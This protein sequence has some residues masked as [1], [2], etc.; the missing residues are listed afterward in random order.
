MHEDLSADVTD[1]LQPE[2]FFTPAHVTICKALYA[3]ANR[4]EANLLAVKKELEAC[5]QLQQI[6][7]GATKEDGV[8][9]LAELVEN[10]GFDTANFGYYAKCVQDAA[11]LRQLLSI[12]QRMY[13]DAK[14]SPVHEATRVIEE[15]QGQLYRLGIEGSVRRPVTTAADAVDAAIVHADKVRRE[16]A[17]AGLMTGFPM[18]DDATGAM[19]AGD[20]WTLAGATS[21]GK[22]AFAL[23]IAANVA[24]A[25]GPVLFVSVEMDSRAIAN[26]LLQARSKIVGGRLRTG[27]LSPEE[28]Q[29]RE[30]TAA[31][32]QQWR[33]SICDRTSTVGS[34][35]IYARR[36]AMRWKQR[37][38]LIVVDY[39]QLLKPISGK[40]RA[41]EIGGLALE[42]KRLAMDTG[43]PVLL[44]S[45]LN[46]EGA[47]EGRPPS[48]YSLKESG[49]VE[50]H[51]NVVLLL[52][53]PKTPKFDT[54]GALIVWAKIAKARDGMT[55]PWPKDGK[56][57]IRLRFKPAITRFEPKGSSS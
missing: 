24:E 14:G 11:A 2:H 19:Q 31:E 53:C 43:T 30:A 18:I 50:N 4:G 46:R 41:Q 26:R 10:C 20:L 33:F 40:T 22:T 35:K 6:G 32:I 9:Y 1:V 49:D 27:N 23:A 34:I 3:V 39:L 21:V 38:G 36:L 28:L 48:L 16:E 29:I 44:L 13:A 55:T 54:D 37:V 56:P 7:H 5:D 42:L 47:R 57:G 52:H 45:Q 8:A 15:Y 51:S 17:E 12:S 25:G